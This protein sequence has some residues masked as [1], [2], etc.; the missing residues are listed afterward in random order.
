M[1]GRTCEWNGCGEP[2]VAKGLCGYHYQR[3]LTGKDMDAPRRRYRQKEPRPPEPCVI[4]GCENFR[5]MLDGLCPMHY[6]RKRSGFPMH[7]PKTRRGDGWTDGRGYRRIKRGNKNV[8]EHRI[9]MED[10]LGRP[11]HP[12]EN[13]HHKNGVRTDNRPENLELWVKSQPSGARAEDLVAWVMD[14]YPELAAE[15]LRSQLRAV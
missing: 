7:L 3:R 10:M 14:T 5:V 11:L 4:E 15:H 9:V 1:S 13:V 12:W 6:Q 2:H 8:F